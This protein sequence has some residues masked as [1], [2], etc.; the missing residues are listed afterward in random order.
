MPTRH[1]SKASI[2][3]PAGSPWR[4]LLFSL[5]F[6]AFVAGGLYFG[7]VFYTTLRAA[8][9]QSSITIPSGGPSLPSLPNWPFVS[10][11]GP[12]APTPTPVPVK[13]GERINVLLLGVDQ[14]PSEKG[15][16]RTDTIIVVTL[17]PQSKT[18]G[19]LS[20]PRDLW[21]KIPDL[22][23]KGITED[24][25]NDAYFFGELYNYPGG[26]PALAMKTIQLNLGIPIHH[27]AVIDFKGFEKIIDTLGGVTINVETPIQDDQYPDDKFGYQSVYIPAGV[28]H[29]D[30]KTALIYARARHEGSDFD[31]AH[32]QQQLLLAIRDQALNLN[33]ITK[34]VPLFNTLKDSV[35]TDISLGD[36]STL[37][38]IAVQI[39]TQNITNRVIDDSLTTPWVTPGGADVLLPKQ[40]EI[41]NLVQEMFFTAP[42]SESS[43]N[44]PQSSEQR[45][46]LQ[47]EGARLELQNGTMTKGLAAQT[48][49]YLESQG[50]QVVSIGDAQRSD[51]QET[52]LIYYSDKPYTQQQLIN[53]FGILP[54]NVRSGA[55]PRRDV[56]IR[57]ILG[58]NVELPGQ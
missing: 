51:Y 27:Y 36:L 14:R 53:L 46:R 35:K 50:Y 44:P 17:D 8:F 39:D 32:R 47:T 19:M 57:L 15:P 31:R 23:A 37:A 20:I 29:M 42:P 26:G 41:R 45:E 49:A 30:G 55:A 25:I 40:A 4:Q 28:Q 3:R 58:T 18:A 54:A 22:G 13:N 11:R 5:F 1:T 56:D 12:E 6:V 21:V 24:R 38:P 7:Y 34:L 2:G 43:S 33:L 16:S 10:S 48:Q 52:V 9:G